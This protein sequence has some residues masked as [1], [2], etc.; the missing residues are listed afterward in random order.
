MPATE[1]DLREL[2]FEIVDSSNVS[3]VD[4]VAWVE[5][6]PRFCG[7]NLPA[8]SIA[9]LF[10]NFGFS[11][12]VLSAFNI[13]TRLVRPQE[14]QKGLSLGTSKGMTRTEWKNKLKAEAQRR[15]PKIKVTLKTADAILL[16][17]YGEQQPET[18]KRK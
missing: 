7:K 18:K 10:R 3:G 12:G 1:G 8:S 14:W 16:L 4:L 2:L 13:E 17:A 6:V 15:F 9:V 5:E 11:L